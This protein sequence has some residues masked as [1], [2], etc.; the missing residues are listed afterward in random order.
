M[1]SSIALIFRF[2]GSNWGLKWKVF[3]RPA[4]ITTLSQWHFNDYIL[5]VLRACFSLIL[6]L[7]KQIYVTKTSKKNWSSHP[8]TYKS[9]NQ[10]QSARDKPTKKKKIYFESRNVCDP[11]SSCFLQRCAQ[12]TVGPMGCVWAE[13]VAVRRAGPAQAATSVCATR[14]ASNTEPARTG[15]AS[16]TRAGTESTAPSV[17]ATAVYVCACGGVRMMCVCVST[18]GCAQENTSTQS[19]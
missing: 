5:H 4:Y 18:R 7:L 12:L 10:C 9:P 2:A 13:L 1:K 15:S 14:S 17:S 6:M 19:D 16:V 8:L 3:R 11:K